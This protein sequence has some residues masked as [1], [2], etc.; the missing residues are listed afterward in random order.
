MLEIGVGL[1]ARR[2]FEENIRREVRNM[3]N[4]LFLKDM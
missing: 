4:I 2:W 1:S 3:E